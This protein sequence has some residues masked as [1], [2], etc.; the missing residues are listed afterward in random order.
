MQ[1]PSRVASALRR[2]RSPNGLEDD[3]TPYHSPLQSEINFFSFNS[4]PAGISVDLILV[5]I[6]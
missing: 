1:R 3:L 2:L 5:G 6:P 4:R